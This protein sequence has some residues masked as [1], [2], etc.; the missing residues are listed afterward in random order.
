M[1]ATA[2]PGGL[3]QRGFLR[4]LAAREAA[5]AGGRAVKAGAAAPEDKAVP[6]GPAE[7][8]YSFP[9]ILSTGNKLSL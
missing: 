9:L 6:G 1:V 3:E 5:Q 7:I 4:L 8:L 2:A